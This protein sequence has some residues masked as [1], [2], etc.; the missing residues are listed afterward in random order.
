MIKELS[1]LGKTLRA[2]KSED[3]WVHDALKEEVITL[4]LNN[5][6]GWQF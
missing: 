2:Q 4:V 5:Q 1:D 3:A 6:T